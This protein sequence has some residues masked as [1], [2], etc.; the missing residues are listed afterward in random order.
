MVMK[1][2]DY[3][4]IT[5]KSEVLKIWENRFNIHLNIQYHRQEN[6]LNSIPEALSNVEV[7]QMIITTNDSKKA[8]RAL[9]NKKALGL[10]HIT[11]EELKTEEMQC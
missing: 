8:I 5:Q 10:D 6:T 2:K 9:K 4:K 7:K 3:K 1:D 11:A